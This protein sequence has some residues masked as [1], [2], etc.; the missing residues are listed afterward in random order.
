M[1]IDATSPIL[2]RHDPRQAAC[3]A[4]FGM[5]SLSFI[6]SF[7]PIIAHDIGIW[8]FHATRSAIVLAALLPMAL[9][10]GWRLQ[11]RNWWAV[12]W[13]SF[14]ISSAMILYFGAVASLP[15]A[16]VAAG[17]LTAPIFVLLITWG[18]Y[19]ARIGRWRVLAVLLGFVGVM[20]VLRPTGG[21]ATALNVIPVGAGLLYA[22]GAVATRQYCAE[23]SE[24]VLVAAFFA[25][26]G[27][28]GALGLL[29]LSETVSDPAINGFFGTGLQPWTKGAL[30]WTFGQA[31]VS[32]VG[33]AALFRAYLLAEASHVAVFEYS[34]LIAAGMW[35]YV[36]WG[37]VPDALALIGMVCIICAGV[38]IIKRSGAA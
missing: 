14:C 11:V 22:M 25:A 37:Q 23:E 9:I 16:Q 28:W 20:L 27:I 10:M 5:V 7:V 13:R 19:G 29:V 2:A 33:I 32:L 18:F 12:A 1:T 21:D 15:V 30:F 35:G 24:A 34:F 8:Q 3:L 6:D 36:L 38:V 4:V 17:L 26:L 31:L